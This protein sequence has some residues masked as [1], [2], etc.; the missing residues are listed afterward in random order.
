MIIENLLSDTLVKK[1]EKLSKESSHSFIV[2]VLLEISSKLFSGNAKKESNIGFEKFMLIINNLLGK[3]A[4]FKKQAKRKVKL[5]F[6][7]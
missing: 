3:Y 5:R 4:P 1:D 2:I 6:K 7:P